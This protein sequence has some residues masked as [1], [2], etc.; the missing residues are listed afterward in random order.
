M[1]A[2]I[3]SAVVTVAGPGFDVQLL[4][5]QSLSGSITALDAKQVTV[6]TD[7]GPTTLDVTKLARISA[8]DKS[9]AIG[10]L[11]SVWIDLVDGTTLLAAEYAVSEDAARITFGD[12]Q[13]AELPAKRIAAVRFQELTDEIAGEW[14]R[15]REMKSDSDLLV[16][17][18]NDTV[19][20]HKGM[21]EGVD[22]STVRFNLDGDV[23][24][25]KRTKVLGIV[26]Y[27]R[28]DG[29]MPATVCG[30][31]DVDGSR[32]AV[33]SLAFADDKLQLSTPAG[34]SVSR[35]LESVKNID[36][37]SGKIV[38]LSDLPTE[39]VK[40][41]PYFGKSDQLPILRKF[42]APRFD[43]GFG[44][45]ELCLDKK[46]YRKGLALHSRTEIVY[47][48]PGRFGRFKA[49]VGIDDAVRPN[50]NVRLVIS[51]DE[52]TLLETTI[53]GNDDPKPVDLDISGVRRLR[54]LVDFGERLDVAD[55][56]DLCEARI[57]K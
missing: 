19:N 8:V 40:W 33:S 34:L 30:L 25:V 32:W 28:G 6:E 23:L 27:R 24:P 50:G 38:Y 47:R 36:F 44:S 26:Y 21:V 7:D 56:L 11:P 20:Y 46:A 29:T 13:Q 39:S 35:P 2:L 43:S 12:K 41:T 57:V 52:R 48:L 31:D 3:L 10:S 16:V 15:I 55:H 14:S 22:E 37:S 51:G 42:F 9:K 45:N 18:K 4:D 49:L 53:D 54:I 17:R 1:F 5:G